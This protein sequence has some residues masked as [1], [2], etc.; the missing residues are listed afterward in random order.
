MNC[1]IHGMDMLVV[2]NINFNTKTYRCQYGREGKTRVH[3]LLI[4]DYGED[5]TIEIKTPW[6]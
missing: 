4:I 1:P 6:S 2:D 5:E 3:I